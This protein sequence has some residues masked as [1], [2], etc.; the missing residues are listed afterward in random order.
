MTI[1]E[2]RDWLRADTEEQQMT[3]LAAVYS[4]LNQ[5]IPE[6]VRAAIRRNRQ[7]SPKNHPWG[8]LATISKEKSG[9]GRGALGECV[10]GEGRAS[11]RGGW[12]CA[13][14]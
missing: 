13:R 14:G 4:R 11:G 12:A 10:R 3:V 8:V 2:L 7:D 1:E 6:A 5:P 9:G